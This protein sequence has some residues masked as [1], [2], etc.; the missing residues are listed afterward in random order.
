MQEV[1]RPAEIA[2]SGAALFSFI[3]Y[4]VVVIGIGVYATR[5]SLADGR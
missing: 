4:L 5:F 1:V 3:G 2:T